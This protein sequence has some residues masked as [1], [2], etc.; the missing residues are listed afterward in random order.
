M[1]FQKFTINFWQLILKKFSRA[2]YII[3]LEAAHYIKL[4]H[5][6]A[7]FYSWIVYNTLKQSGMR[8]SKLEKLKFDS[9]KQEINTL[10]TVV[11][12][13]HQNG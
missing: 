3:Y 13:I 9:I 5:F 11:D 1:F 7:I 10:D 4:S 8:K 12:K 2:K 6:M